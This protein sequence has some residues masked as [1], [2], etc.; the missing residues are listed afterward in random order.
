ME[1]LPNE[2]PE[3]PDFLISADSR[4]AKQVGGDFYDLIELSDEKYAIVIGD[5]AGKG[6]PA[7]LLMSMT[8]S[9]L[10]FALLK[11]IDLTNV[12]VEVNTY[13][14][15]ET[16]VEKFVT[17]QILLIDQKEKRISMVNAG[18]G[19]LLIYRRFTD[20]FEE[21]VVEGLA[22]G[23]NPNVDYDQVETDYDTGDIRSNSGYNS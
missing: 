20:T 12:I 14:A 1:L 4:P 21:L 11:S 16:P 13:L 5:V 10:K 19:P 3:V 7:S 15:N 18:H 8:K 6:I 2:T 23:I 22:L 9:L 17:V